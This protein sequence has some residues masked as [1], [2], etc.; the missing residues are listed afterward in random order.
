MEKPERVWRDAPMSYPSPHNPE[1]IFQITF[2]ICLD[3]WFIKAVFNRFTTQTTLQF[4]FLIKRRI[5]NVNR[6]LLL[7]LQMGVFNTKHCQQLILCLLICSDQMH[8]R[9]QMKYVWSDALTCSLSS[10]LTS[11]EER[12]FFFWYILSILNS[13]T[14]FFK[15]LE[16]FPPDSLWMSTRVFPFKLKHFTNSFSWINLHTFL[17]T[18][19]NT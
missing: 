11:L 4:F 9:S 12:A 17:V 10:S 6:V 18:I 1:E 14:A 7:F 8:T 19:F 5:E 2:Y 13:V 16:C 15:R 3:C